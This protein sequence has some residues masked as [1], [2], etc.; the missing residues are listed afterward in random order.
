MPDFSLLSSLLSGG[1]L[2]RKNR[3]SYVTHPDVIRYFDN[4]LAWTMNRS[5]NLESEFKQIINIA[6]DE[7]VW[8]YEDDL[9]DEK[10]LEGVLAFLDMRELAMQN[11]LDT[12]G[13][14]ESARTA[15]QPPRSGI[16]YAQP[17][18]DFWED[19]HGD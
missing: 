17:P 10:E 13:R 11:E 14:L 2:A 8:S 15:I 12:Y 18:D 1:E 9:I 4:L 3:Q 7:A 5:Q 6:R 19:S 16:L